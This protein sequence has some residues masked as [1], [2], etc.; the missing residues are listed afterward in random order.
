MMPVSFKGL[1]KTAIFSPQQRRA[2]APR[3]TL[4]DT[5]D[6]AWAAHLPTGSI[7]ASLPHIQTT[8]LMRAGQVPQ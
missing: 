1:Y 7:T 3:L 2:A 6:P 4:T 8:G 5:E